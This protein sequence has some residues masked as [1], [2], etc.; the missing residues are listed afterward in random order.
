MY[1]SE[2]V[3]NELAK[4]DSLNIWNLESEENE[5][6]KLNQI[7][8]GKFISFTQ[9][10]IEFHFEKKLIHKIIHNLIDTKYKISENF[11]EQID[12]LIE[13]ADYN[14]IKKFEPEKDILD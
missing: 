7:Y 13:N 5:E 3:E 9:N 8:F 4:Q 11:I 10:L 6:Y 12:S 2:D 14:N 1:I